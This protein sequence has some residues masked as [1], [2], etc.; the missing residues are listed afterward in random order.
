MWRAITKSK[1]INSRVCRSITVG[2]LCPGDV[3][4]RGRR[5]QPARTRAER[6]DLLACGTYAAGSSK[7]DALSVRTERETH[8][9]AACSC[10]SSDMRT[11]TSYRPKRDTSLQTRIEGHHVKRRIEK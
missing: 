4:V 1:R 11:D 7:E 8:W 9:L 3:V 2:G 6:P 5:V 10:S